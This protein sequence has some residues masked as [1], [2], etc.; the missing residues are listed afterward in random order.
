VRGA[1]RL[2]T[3]GGWRPAIPRLSLCLAL[4]CSA[5]VAEEPAPPL[6]REA[7]AETGLRF[8]HDNGA[9]GQFALPEIMGAGAALFDYDNDGDLDAFLV[10]SGPLDRNARPPAGSRL[11]RN[12]L[13]V[14]NGRTFPRYS[15]VTEA[16]GIAVNTF[17]MGAA[18]GDIDSDGDLD[19]YV[20]GFGANTLYRNEGDGTFRDATRE[21]GLVDARW[22]TSAA[23]VDYD[24]DGDLDLY[25]GHYVA[26]TMAGNKTCT[27][28]VGVRDYC[29][30]AAWPAVPDRLLRNDG[31]GRFTDVSEPAGITRAYGPALGVAVGDLDADG[32]PDIYVAN[33]AQP[34]QLWRNRR[35][36]TFEDIGLLSGSA[37]NAGGRPEG[38]MGIALGDPD[39]DGD[40]DIFVSNLVGESHV[41]YANDGT[42]NFE[43]ARTPAE[44]GRATAA[45]T[46]FG[47]GWFDYDHDGWLDLFIANGA[48]NI[49]EALRGQPNP[50][51]QRN[52]LFHNQ[53]SGR[54]RE[55][56]SV[57]GPA[58]E[59][60]EVSRG[61]AFGDVDSDGDVDILVTNNNGPVRLLLNERVAAPLPPGN[62]RQTSDSGPLRGAMAAEPGFP[63]WLEI[64]LR[65][66][67]GNRFGIGARIGIVRSGEPTV[68]RRARS[69]GSYLSASDQRVHVGL[70]A[71]SALD[72]V[73]VEWPDGLVERF[74]PVPP[75]ALITLNRGAGHTLAPPGG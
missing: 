34:N 3:D 28:P 69:D 23:F 71:R 40:E 38:S 12:D 64:G 36:G 13:G 5:P 54:F 53:G 10:Q 11:F 70:G 41:L 15:D 17:G 51:R 31:D 19:L 57:A 20:S 55:V 29:A 25:V 8:T 45:M 73:I 39:N 48:V 21:A 16:A 61:A 65:A 56:T 26:F 66:D 49:V 75:D 22:S 72:A 67:T 58:F 42:G 52:Q 6:F 60:L 27:D 47:T 74:S 24:R 50:F 46:G 43:D 18:V 1:A 37:V 62:N 63:H 30:P 14:E 68:W 9:G 33:D 44:L 7:A 32:W 59:A 2:A 4:L 35:D